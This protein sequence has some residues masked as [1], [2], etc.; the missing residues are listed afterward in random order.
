MVLMGMREFW[1]RIINLLLLTLFVISPLIFD[2]FFSL[3]GIV[4]SSSKVVSPVVANWQEEIVGTD[5]IRY[6]L[7]PE[8]ENQ[9]GVKQTTEI[10]AGQV[11]GLT[12]YS[13]N[14]KVVESYKI[15]VLGDSMIDVMQP[16]LPQLAGALKKYYPQAK[17][18]LLNYGVG[19]TNIEYG[20]E[21]LTSD[22]D[23]MGR[24]YP[25]LLSCNP[26]II[27]IESFA[28][29]HWGNNKQDL[30]RQRET[31][32][33]IIDTIKSQSRA[34]IVLA[35]TIGPDVN[36]LCDG[37]E[38]INLSAKQKREKADTIKAYLD[39]LVNFANS[40]NLP[41]ANAYHASLDDTGYGK[42][43]YVNAGDH[44]HPSGPGGELVAEKIAEAI[45]SNNLL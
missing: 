33:K 7:L 36:T 10:T 21:R 18:E 34:K 31:L 43:I 8:A 22:Y 20:L 41:L 38:G 12:S 14:Y 19:A 23:Y 24:H 9:S 15:A 16:E 37:I 42:V 28:Y 35:A 13:P 1:G 4:F 30:D 26:D 40:N 44:L 5:T 25:A 29:N 6:A 32:T 3:Q 39:N 45:L 17:F 27:V 2:S 11:K